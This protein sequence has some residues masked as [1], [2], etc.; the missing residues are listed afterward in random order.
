MA[1]PVTSDKTKSVPLKNSPVTKSGLL[2][3]LLNFG[4]GLRFFRDPDYR[5][6]IWTRT[7]YVFFL[8]LFVFSIYTT[9]STTFWLR[10]L[11]PITTGLNPIG[12]VSTTTGSSIRKTHLDS[13]WLPLSHQNKI[14]N[15]DILLT[16]KDSNI[17]VEI[18]RDVKITV[19]P[20][21][22]VRITWFDGKPLIRLSK[23]EIKTQFTND[24]V[25]LIKKGPRIEEVLIRK[26]S[27]LIKNDMSAGI[28]ITSFAQETKSLAGLKEEAK[29]KAKM[30]DT[31]FEEPQ[32]APKVTE[33]T[34]EA[35]T[36][37]YDLPTPSEGTVFLLK[38][39][40]PIFIGAKVVCPDQCQMTLYRDNHEFKSFKWKRN[41]SSVVSI[42][43]DEVQPGQYSWSFTSQMF[44]YKSAFS[45]Q[46]FSEQALEKA[47][48]NSQPIEV[49][50][51]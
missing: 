38:N 25:V 31:S 37:N 47:I 41:E 9:I 17:E 33:A 36:V 44:E 1:I 27:Y 5:N 40:Q 18:N 4:Q 45:I 14:F 30:K 51:E 42:E 32:T 21:S 7:L 29:T 3:S 35:P 6:L 2:F 48:D 34:E 15:S 23:G 24:Q 39:A 50:G 16:E 11:E 49:L 19:E 20:R 46:P 26:G 13:L 28:Q 43:S 12:H 10:F 22:L 8:G